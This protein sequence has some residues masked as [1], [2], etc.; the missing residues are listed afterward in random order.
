MFEKLQ[1]YA[2]NTMLCQQSWLVV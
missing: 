2:D 1:S